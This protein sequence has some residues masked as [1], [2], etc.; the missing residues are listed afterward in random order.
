MDNCRWYGGVYLI[1]WIILEVLSIIRSH[2]Y[3]IF[4]T[5]LAIL[6]V[7]H[8]SAQPYCRKWLNITDGFLLVSLNFT[9]SLTLGSDLITERV[10]LVYL[11]ILIPLTYIVLGVVAILLDCCGMLS[12]MRKLSLLNLRCGRRGIRYIQYKILELYRIWKK[13]W[14]LW[15]ETR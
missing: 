10:V 13:G 3:L 12:K 5:V 9:T 8:F 14:S 2:D 6:T 15:I 1:S 7:V 11:S 4:Q